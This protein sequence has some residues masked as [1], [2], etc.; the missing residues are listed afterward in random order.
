LLFELAFLGEVHADGFRDSEFFHGN[1]V[2]DV[3]SGHGS[4]AVGDDD[5]LGLVDEAVEDFEEALDVGFVKGGVELVEHAEGAGLD[6]V[7]GEEEG[8]GSHG[9]L[10]TGEEGDALE[11]FPGR[12][13]DDFDSGVERVFVV[14]EDE[15]GFG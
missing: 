6:H 15:V 5:E 10:T 2:H 14:D 4:F 12:F 3:S 8:D 7:D 11:L 9:A 1:A 13:G